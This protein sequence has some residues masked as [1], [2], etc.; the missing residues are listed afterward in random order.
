MQPDAPTL[1]VD[2]AELAALRRAADA[3]A[4][5]A[6][7]AGNQ[8]APRRVVR[9]DAERVALRGDEQEVLRLEGGFEELERRDAAVHGDVVDQAERVGGEHVNLHARALTARRIT[10]RER[11]RNEGGGREGREREPGEVGKVRRG[12]REGVS[13][14]ER[15]VRDGGGRRASRHATSRDVTRRRASDPRAGRVVREEG[16]RARTTRRRGTGGRGTHATMRLRSFSSVKCP[17]TLCVTLV[18]LCACARPGGRRGAEEG[19]QIRARRECHRFASA[20]KRARGGRRARGSPRAR[21]PSPRSCTPRESTP[22][23]MRGTRRA[24]EIARPDPGFEGRRW[25]ARARRWQSAA[26]A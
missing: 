23:R 7:R 17:T 14:S 26:A 2:D 20:R 9:K 3:V 19:G 24:G 12:K 10:Q 25:S 16:R 1:G 15:E 8:L 22:W 11:E 21:A 6:R 18:G 4:Q 13:A 5:I